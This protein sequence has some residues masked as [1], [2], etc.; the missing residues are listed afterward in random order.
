MY[1]ILLLMKLVISLS[2]LNTSDKIIHVLTQ[3]LVV[4]PPIGLYL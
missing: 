2:K 1:D 3:L 4:F